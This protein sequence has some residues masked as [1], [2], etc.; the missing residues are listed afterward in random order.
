MIKITTKKGIIIILNP[1]NSKDNE[2]LY[3]HMGL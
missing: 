2:Y 1:H 3:N